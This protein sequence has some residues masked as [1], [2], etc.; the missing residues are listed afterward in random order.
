M[1]SLNLSGCEALEDVSEL[2]DLPGLNSLELSKCYALH[3]VSGLS[4]LTGLTSLVLN[5]CTALVDLSGLSGLTGLTSLD[6]KDCPFVDHEANREV[7][8]NL[9]ALD[10]LGGIGEPWNTLILWNAAR[11]RGGKRGM[12]PLLKKLLELCSSPMSNSRLRAD[13]IEGLAL[14]PCSD[15]QMTVVH[16]LSWSREE[17]ARLLVVTD[18]RLDPVGSGPQ[19]GLNEADEGPF[20][21]EETAHTLFKEAGSGQGAFNVGSGRVG[22]RNAMKGYILAVADGSRWDG[23]KDVIDQAFAQATAEL[24]RE[25]M[26]VHPSWD[27]ATVDLL[28]AL[29]GLGLDKKHDALFCTVTDASRQAFDQRLRISAAEAELGQGHW[30]KALN[31]M[32]DIPSSVE[33]QMMS[34]IIPMVVGQEVPEVIL[35]WMETAADHDLGLL[36]ENTGMTPA[37]GLQNRRI[38]EQLF[39]LSASNAG[40]FRDLVG[41]MFAAFPDDPWVLALMTEANQGSASPTAGASATD[42]IRES[43]QSETLAALLGPMVGQQL[44]TAV[45]GQT[46]AELHRLAVALLLEHFGAVTPQ[47]RESILSALQSENPTA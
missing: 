16:G 37:E 27:E 9:D 11:R 36:V 29:K 44:Q 2:I 19:Y 41:Q 42:G 21:V 8:S 32:Q 14:A 4:V 31:H 6:V 13:F 38:R 25:G 43:L 26:E 18:N 33:A 35:Q 47:F 12:S 46:E 22:I 10:R 39:W 28:M 45:E 34:R 15:E 17:W 1:T 40:M 3:D 23:T 24:A 7:I 20:L 5:R 30:G